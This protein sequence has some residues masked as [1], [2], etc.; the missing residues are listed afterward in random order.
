MLKGFFHIPKK[1]MTSGKYKN[2][3]VEPTK[4]DLVSH[5]YI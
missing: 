1:L 4:V 2:V 5:T 3:H